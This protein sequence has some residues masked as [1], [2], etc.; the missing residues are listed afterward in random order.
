MD[1][2][3]ECAGYAACPRASAPHGDDGNPD[4]T[5]AFQ[6]SVQSL[7]ESLAKE[8]QVYGAMAG[9]VSLTKPVFPS[10]EPYRCYYTSRWYDGDKSVRPVQ[11][12]GVW[13][14]T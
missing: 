1:G 10:T 14:S 13:K 12:V 8:L 9:E 6:K 11:L 7:S 3:G 5:F 4:G 2:Q